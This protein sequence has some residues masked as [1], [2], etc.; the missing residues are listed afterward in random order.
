VR[1]GMGR[2]DEEL[3]VGAIR[4]KKKK[5]RRGA[6]CWSRE[7]LLPHSQTPNSCNLK[8]TQRERDGAARE[9][10]QRERWNLAEIRREQTQQ[11][12]LAEI[13]SDS[14]HSN[15]DGRAPTPTLILG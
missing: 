11:E 4:D 10:T 8:Q 1:M 13:R 7:S 3:Y 12:N 6:I 9:Q 14:D 15:P 5:R 2:R